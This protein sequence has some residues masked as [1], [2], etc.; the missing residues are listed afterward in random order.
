[1]AK[2]KT[3]K[4]YKPQNIFLRTE[5]SVRKIDLQFM[6]SSQ[7]PLRVDRYRLSVGKKWAK[8]ER[9]NEPVD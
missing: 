8:P 5:Y 3:T 2:K 9:G 7:L 1:M 4:T 6:S